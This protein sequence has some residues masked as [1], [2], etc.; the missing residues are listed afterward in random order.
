MHFNGEYNILQRSSSVCKRM[1]L[2]SFHLLTSLCHHSFILCDQIERN[3]SIR[4]RIDW[5]FMLML[6]F[7]LQKKSLVPLAFWRKTLFL[8]DFGVRARHFCFVKSAIFNRFIWQWF[9]IEVTNCCFRFIPSQ[10]KLHAFQLN[11][12]ENLCAK[13]MKERVFM[14]LLWKRIAQQFGLSLPWFSC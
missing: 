4:E 13:Q 12:I 2:F 11:W 3:E 7:F 8:V 10:F 6:F 5:Q 9:H 1:K 14:H